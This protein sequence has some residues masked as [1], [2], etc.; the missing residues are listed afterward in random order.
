LLAQKH[1]STVMQVFFL[2]A[3]VSA[4]LSTVDSTLLAAAALTSHNLIVPCFKKIGETAKV[5]IARGG[6]LVAGLVALVLALQSDSIHE[7]VQSASSFGSAGI[8]VVTVMGLFT[9]IGGSRAAMSAMVGATAV[10]GAGTWI[11]TIPLVYLA[12]LFAAL[13]AY[14]TVAF[15]EKSEPGFVG[16]TA[17]E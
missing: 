9:R 13:F 2:G 16:D 3:L 8:F 17:G 6:V 11:L 5:N 14:F 15:F 7:L 12:S 4:I 1:L 10:W